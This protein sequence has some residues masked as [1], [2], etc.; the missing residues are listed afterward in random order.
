VGAPG[1]GV[2]VDAVVVELVASGNVLAADSVVH[3]GLDS[4]GSNNVDSDLLLTS[5]DSHAASESLNGTLGARVDGVLGNTLGLASDGAHKDDAATDFHPLVCLLGNE[6]LAA[7]VDGHD[8]VVLL[9]S[10]ILEVTEGDDT[11]VG[12]ADVELAESFDNTVHELNGLLNVA[13]VGLD[14]NC[15]RAILHLLDLLNH[16]LG[17]LGA[18][19]IVDNN[20]CATAS[21]LKSHLLADTTACAISQPRASQVVGLILSCAA[22]LTRAGNDGDLAL[23]APGWDSVSGHCDCCLVDVVVGRCFKCGC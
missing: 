4:T 10:H 1:L 12:A 17:S 18:V 14:G 16:I 7:G 5:I 6:E 3:V 22:A 13:N 15:I 2:L 19:G 11:R 20:L 23:Q 9:L 21:K 8:T